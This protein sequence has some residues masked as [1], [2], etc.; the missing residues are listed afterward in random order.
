MKFMILRK[1]NAETETAVL[2]HRL[3]IQYHYW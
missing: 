2:K 1:A 3:I